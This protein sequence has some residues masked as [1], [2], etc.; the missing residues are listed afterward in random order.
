MNRARTAPNLFLEVRSFEKII[1]Y[2]QE[3]FNKKA[4]TKKHEKKTTTI[5]NI[6]NIFEGG[7]H[8]KNNNIK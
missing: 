4:K 1:F 2:E 8:F 7:I 3:H 6:N 5:T